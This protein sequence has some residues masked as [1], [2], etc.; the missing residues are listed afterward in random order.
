M[1][2]EFEESDVQSPFMIIM[3]I[4]VIMTLIS[5]GALFHQ[6]LTIERNKAEILSLYALIPIPDIQKVFNSCD[7][8][9][10]TLNVG[11]L[12]SQLQLGIN[13]QSLTEMRSQG[14]FAHSSWDAM[15]SGMIDKRASIM[16]EKDLVGST[17]S[18][19]F[20]QGI[21]PI[22]RM[23]EDITESDDEMEQN[24]RLLN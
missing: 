15:G 11:S 5:F 14:E 1:H 21:K 8:F 3:I 7:E 12:T 9:M 16:N 24:R 6:L 22:K 19:Q 18:L 20:G 2:R 10:E 23:S 4:G 17:D 13:K